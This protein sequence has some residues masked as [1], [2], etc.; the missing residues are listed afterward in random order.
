MESHSAMGREN[1]IN[2]ESGA[3]RN[4]TAPLCPRVSRGV[5]L[6]NDERRK[7]ERLPLL[8]RESAEVKSDRQEVEI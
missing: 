8:T 4:V 7:S 1:Q 3:V 5:N 2:G 6:M